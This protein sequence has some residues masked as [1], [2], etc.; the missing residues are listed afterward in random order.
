M[1]PKLNQLREERAQYDE[2]CKLE[3]EAEHLTRLYEA[4]QLCIAQK[5]T[6]ASKHAMEK[7]HAKLKEIEDKIQSNRELIRTT[8]V[9]IEESHKKASAVSKIVFVITR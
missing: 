5:N 4:W 1:K 3:R 7:G 9:E 2:Y 8:E 6:A